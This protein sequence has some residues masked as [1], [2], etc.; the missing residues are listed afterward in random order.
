MGG[1]LPEQ[2][3]LTVFRRVLD[4]GCGPGGWIFEAAQAYP[5]MK[6]QQADFVATNQLHTLWALN[7]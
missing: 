3:E 5:E 6:L 1:V 2:P 7:S 4:I